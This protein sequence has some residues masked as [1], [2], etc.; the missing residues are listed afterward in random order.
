LVSGG[1]PRALPV[2][3]HRLQHLG[4]GFCQFSVPAVE[5]VIQG[6]V[7]NRFREHVIRVPGFVV[8]WR[9]AFNIG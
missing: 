9:K 3:F 2:P 5:I 4:Q 7:D 6:K 8:H 1:N